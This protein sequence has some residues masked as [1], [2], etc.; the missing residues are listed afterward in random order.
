MVAPAVGYDEDPRPIIPPYYI[1][2]D[3]NFIPGA[4][5]SQITLAEMD[6]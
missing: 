3:Y 6:E 1:T 4:N 2:K 5:Y